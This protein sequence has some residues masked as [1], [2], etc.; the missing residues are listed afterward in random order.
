MYTAP[1]RTE[2]ITIPTGRSSSRQPTQTCPHADQTSQVVQGER[3]VEGLID[4]PQAREDP[5]RRILDRPQ[6]RDL[7]RAGKANAVGSCLLPHSVPLVPLGQRPRLK[8]SGP[9]CRRRRSTLGP[10]HRSVVTALIMRWS[11]QRRL[12]MTGA[13]SPEQAV[14]GVRCGGPVLRSPVRLM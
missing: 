4:E 6:A 12:E 8:A 1:S 9:R 10:P 11:R 13:A 14:L 7:I 3:H 5:A 2:A